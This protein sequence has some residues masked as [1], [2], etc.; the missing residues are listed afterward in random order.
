MKT[1]PFHLFLMALLA[2]AVFTTPAFSGHVRNLPW[3][4]MLLGSARFRLVLGGAAVLDRE[5]GLV[6]DQ[7][8]GTTV[9]PW[10]AAFRHCFARDVGD[11]SGW[12]LPTAEEL[13]TLKDPTQSGPALPESHPFSGVPNPAQPFYWTATSSAEFPS[14]AWFVNF[15]TGNVDDASKTLTLSVW[16]VRGGQGYDG[17]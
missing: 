10:A 14:D 8:P 7:A 4:H 15:S 5:T 6:W 16:C 13:A 3:D 12:R 17:R 11:R 9:V 2:C 1:K